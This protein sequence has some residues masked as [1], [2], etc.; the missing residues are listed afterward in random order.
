MPL[1]F[2]P[3]PEP[4]PPKASGAPITTPPEPSPTSPP[5]APVRPQPPILTFPRPSAAP[6]I[7]M[8][9]QRPSLTFLRPAAPMSP[10]MPSPASARHSTATPLSLPF[11]Q[12]YVF[13]PSQRGPLTLPPTPGSVLPVPPGLTL[14]PL[15]L[16]AAET[17]LTTLPTPPALNLPTSSSVTKDS[18][19][20]KRR[21]SE[22]EAE[23]SDSDTE[24][25]GHKRKKA[26]GLPRTNE[27]GGT[28]AG[29]KSFEYSEQELAE[30]AARK[31]LR[32]RW[33]TGCSETDRARAL[34]IALGKIGGGRQ[35][36]WLNQTPATSAQTMDMARAR[37]L[38]THAGVIAR[39]LGISAEE[40]VDPPSPSPPPVR[41][42][43]KAKPR[44]TPR[45]VSSLKGPASAGYCVTTWQRGGERLG[46]VAAAANAGGTA[47]NAGASATNR[48]ATDASAFINAGGVANPGADGRADDDGEEDDDDDDLIRLMID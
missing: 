5:P 26:N 46:H 40:I 41:A 36:S 47:A 33:Q 45:P 34:N 44:P 37:D 35:Y 27:N 39:E 42:K 17:S 8:P 28:S 13:T 16:E 19:G 21:A 9:P 25:S 10:Q 7:T 6:V 20:R 12:S 31:K 15:R 43:P 11:S 22:Q 38:N 1:P 48:V 29:R 18:T 30:R 32:T 2:P 24:P 4:M 14:P 3:R 23:E